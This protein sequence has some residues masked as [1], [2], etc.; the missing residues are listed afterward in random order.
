MSAIID[1]KRAFF[2]GQFENCEEL[3]LEVPDE[4]EDWYEGHVVLCMNTPIYGVELA[5]YFFFKTFA[6]HIKNMTYKQS[7][8]DP[9]S[10]F[11]L[12]CNAIVVFVAWVDDFMTLRPPHWLNRSSMT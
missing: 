10:V 2:Q 1:V 4:F 11:F 7:K 8:A 3:Y 6:K 9:M 12:G 5:T